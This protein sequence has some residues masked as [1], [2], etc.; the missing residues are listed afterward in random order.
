M[1]DFHL[2]GRS[3]VFAVNGLCATSHPLAA[4]TAVKILED[5]GNAVDASIGAAALLGFCEPQ[6]TG[7][8]GDCFVLLKPIGEDNRVIALNGS[9]RAPKAASSQSLRDQGLTEVPK[10]SAHA[11]TVPGAVDAFCRLSE[12]W[13][14]LGLEASLSPA[15][16]YAEMGVPVA[17]RVAF[18]WNRALLAGGLQGDGK[19][20]FLLNGQAPKPGEIFRAAGQAEVLRRIAKQGRKGF[21]EGEV[22]NDMVDS[23][24]RHGGCHSLEDFAATECSYSEPIQGD[25]RG[26]E[27]L[28]HP[29]N[30]Q[31]AAALLLT[32]ILQHLEFPSGEPFGVQRTHLECEAVRLAY[33]AR[34]RFIADPDHTKQL[35][36]IL[37]AGTAA[38]LAALIDPEKPLNGLTDRTSAVHRETVLLNVVDR[39][40]MAVSMIY[41]IFHSFGS[42]IASRKFGINFQNR[43]AGFTLEV[44]HPNEFNGSKRP[45]HTIIPAMLKQHGKVVMPFGVMG[46]QYQAAGHARLVTNMVDY[47]MHPQQALDGPRSFPE[48]GI[49]MLERGHEAHVMDGLRR[50]GHDVQ[51]PE[52]PLGGGQAIWID[53][54]AGVLQGVSDHRKDGCAIGY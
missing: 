30:G 51:I 1:R 7:L 32:N 47:G 48:D 11:V 26:Y 10:Y 29:P 38:K 28:E 6:S 34:D 41:S 2:P 37:A 16:Q 43:G 39:D 8:G 49:L 54:H 24:V 3:A 15:I 27:I 35:D 36:H 31:G 12:D 19:R 52:A 21:Y 45:F 33:D 5:G 46:G 23:L 20:H 14:R 50:R 53:H 13:G 40:L 42:G 17:P 9:G 22:A 4:H 18:D 25:Y 44:G